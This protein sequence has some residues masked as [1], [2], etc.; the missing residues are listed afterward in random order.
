VSAVTVTVAEATPAGANDDPTFVS[1]V[2]AVPTVEAE[3]ATAVDAHY[4]FVAAAHV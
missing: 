1:A 4:V 2:V 3:I